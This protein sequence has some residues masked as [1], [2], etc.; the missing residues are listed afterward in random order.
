MKGIIPRG[1]FSKKKSFRGGMLR[2]VLITTLT[3]AFLITR[4]GI[5]DPRPRVRKPLTDNELRQVLAGMTVPSVSAPLAGSR[6]HRLAT[7]GRKLFLD[8]GLSSNG[9]VSCATCHRPDKSFTDGLPVAKGVGTTAR[10]A[11]T[12][13]NSRF[14]H[15]FFWDGRADSLAAQAAGPL[16]NPD[17]HGLDRESLAT[18]ILRRHAAEYHELFGS[19]GPVDATATGT[20]ASTTAPP[21]ELK[22]LAAYTLATIGPYDRMKAVLTIAA[23]RA[24]QPATLISGVLAP[25]TPAAYAPTGRADHDRDSQIIANAVTAI[26][27]WERLLIA[28]QSPFDAF[29]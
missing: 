3:A 2:L 21:L 19:G 20:S 12:I 7:F 23:D 25:A 1:P 9:Q 24:T 26:A 6:E 17:E 4:Q 11:P 5:L 29:A 8:P 22:R 18:A 15:W 28:D 16:E 14:A 10:N 13:I 27:A